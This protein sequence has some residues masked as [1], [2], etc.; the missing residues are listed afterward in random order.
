MFDLE[1]AVVY[2]IIGI[3]FL[4]IIGAIVGV[5]VSIWMMIAPLLLKIIWT[6]VLVSMTLVFIAATL[7]VIEC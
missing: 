4:L 6:I 3:V 5:A 2:T 1:N 7:M